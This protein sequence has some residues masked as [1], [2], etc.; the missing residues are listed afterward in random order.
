MIDTHIASE[1]ATIR[2]MLIDKNIKKLDY[3]IISHYHTDHYGN[4]ENLYNAGYITPETK[5]FL[6]AE[7]RTFPVM[8]EI[9]WMKNFCQQHNLQYFVPTE[10]TV[11]PVDED[12]DF[13][14]F[15]CDADLMD[16]Y[17]PY[18]DKDGNN[19]SMSVLIRYKK[20]KL[21]YTGDTRQ[22]VAERMQKENFPGT[23]VN[24]YKIEHHGINVR[25]APDWI[26]KICPDI[27][28]QTAGMT[29]FGMGEFSRCEVVNILNNLGCDIVPT[30]VQSEPI[31]LESDG[32]SVNVLSGVC[33]AYSAGTII[34]SIYVDQANA[35]DIQDGTSEH[36]FKTIS[37][38]ISSC[39]Y[40]RYFY[41][42]IHVAPGRY[43]Y[44][45]QPAGYALNTRYNVLNVQD[46]NGQIIISGVSGNPGAVV[47]NGVNIQDSHVILNHM[48]IDVD[49]Q[50]DGIYARF[51]DVHVNDVVIKSMTNT[52]QA[53]H[54]GIYMNHSNVYVQNSSIDHCGDCV[55]ITNGSTFKSN[56]LRYGAN[57]NRPRNLESGSSAI[58]SNSTYESDVIRH[59]DTVIH[60]NF[61]LPVSVYNNQTAEFTSTSFSVPYNPSDFNAVIIEYIDKDGIVG[62]TGIQMDMGNHWTI[63]RTDT[64]G[65]TNAHITFQTAIQWKDGTVTYQRNNTIT[66]KA[67][68]TTVV[69]ANERCIHITRIIG[70][71]FNLLDRTA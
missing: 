66:H 68:G 43:C 31:E 33:G 5:L 40:D 13:T 61:A 69:T 63:L 49:N 52:K 14:F 34:R 30:F 56:G 17:A 16:N 26:S 20:A 4:F 25:V 59:N 41:A 15:N 24:L 45:L 62:N 1:W 19:T 60:S 71:K 18:N 48:T 42:E 36:P 50:N 64:E 65:A 51:A 10:L 28:V 27:A 29:R 21:L 58:M 12:M 46:M 11:Y 47:V 32:E 55:N 35:G 44:E 38:A 37:Q 39:H 54:F 3:V 8:N 67:D 23:K 70:L 22:P 57:I 53:G 2:S 6:P 7:T 9:A